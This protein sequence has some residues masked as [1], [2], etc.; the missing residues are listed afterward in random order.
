MI[1]SLIKEVQ[2]WPES[3]KNKTKQNLASVVSSATKEC[4]V[5]PIPGGP[6]WK[7]GPGRKRMGRKTEIKRQTRWAGRNEEIVLLEEHPTTAYLRREGPLPSECS[8]STRTGETMRIR[9]ISPFSKLFPDKWKTQINQTNIRNWSFHLVSFP[10]AEE[11]SLVR[12]NSLKLFSKGSC[13]W[14]S[15]IHS[16]GEAAPYSRRASMTLGY[17]LVS[18]EAAYGAARRGSQAAKAAASSCVYAEGFKAAKC[19]SYPTVLNGDLGFSKHRR[20]LSFWH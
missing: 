14:A 16:L 11:E 10:L 7:S 2:L 1:I 17:H 4:C 13:I 6:K 20:V 12:L 8:M 19:A 3:G 5:C 9:N 15:N 18:K